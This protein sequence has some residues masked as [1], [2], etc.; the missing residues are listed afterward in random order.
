MT[1]EE[2]LQI[3][4]QKVDELQRHLKQ[5]KTEAD[6]QYLNRLLDAWRSYP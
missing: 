5:A 6:R 2:I 4:Y 1:T 3:K